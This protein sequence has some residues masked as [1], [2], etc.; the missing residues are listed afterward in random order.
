MDINKIL[1]ED[2]L[3]VKLEGRLDTNTAPELEKE[4]KNDIPDVKE[5]IL[6]FEELKYISSAGLRVVLQT[7]KIMMSKQGSMVVENVNDLIMEIF[8]TTGFKDILTIKDKV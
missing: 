8:E 3:T 6:D 7:Q 1:E 4:L 2:K 5:L